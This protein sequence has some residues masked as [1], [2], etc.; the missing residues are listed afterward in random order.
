[1]RERPE[2]HDINYGTGD[3]PEPEPQDVPLLEPYDGTDDETDNDEEY[4]ITDDDQEKIL[5]IMNMVDNYDVEEVTRIY[6]Q[7]NGDAN[8]VAEVLLEIK[9]MG[10]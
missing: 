3:E 2:H 5:M 9:N 10:S 8:F 7:Y 1:M 4:I 6:K